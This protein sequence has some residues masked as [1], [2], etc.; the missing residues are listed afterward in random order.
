MKK[1]NSDKARHMCICES[2]FYS[3]FLLFDMVNGV[4]QH[5]CSVNCYLPFKSYTALF[6][7]MG[8]SHDFSYFILKMN[9]KKLYLHSEP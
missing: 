2:R 7:E 8:V 3:F 5:N 9:N 1:T 6:V 4:D